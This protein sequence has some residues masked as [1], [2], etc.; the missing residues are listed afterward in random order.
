MD[1]LHEECANLNRMNQSKSNRGGLGKRRLARGHAAAQRNCLSH[2]R[3]NSQVFL[4][5]EPGVRYY[6]S[7]FGKGQVRGQDD[8]G[9]LGPLG[10]D[11][12]EELGAQVCHGHVAHFVDGDQVIA[13]PAGQ[14]TAQLQLLLSLDQ[15][16]DQRRSRQAQTVSAIPC[17]SSGVG[18]KTVLPA[19]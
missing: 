5:G 16:V 9:L 19:K 12:E 1:S 17:F 8:G 13:F 2:V 14:Y 7:P 6:L 10:D 18:R 15:L 11:L 4:I 3:S